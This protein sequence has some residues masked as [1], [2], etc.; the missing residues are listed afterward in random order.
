M[1]TRSASPSSP[2]T[3]SAS[4]TLLA[5]RQRLLGAGYRLFYQQPL[6]V[7]RGDGVWLYD[8]DGNRYLDVYNNV[9]S[10]G[11]CHPAVVEAI[12]TQAAT[13]NTHTRYLT[14]AI[15]DFAED[16]LQEFP[17]PLQNI[18]LTCS[19]SE[20][21]DLAL[22][23][24]R[25]VT[26]G[27]GVMVTRWAYHGV[28]AQL[29][30]LSPS[31]GSGAPRGEQVWL[32]DPPDGYRRQ[33]GCLLASVKQALAQMEQAGVRPAAMLFDTLF[34]SDGVFS[35]PAQEVQEAVRLVRSAG[36]LFIADEV[37][38]GF[39]RTGNHRWGFGAYGVVPDLVTLGK[40][41]G[42]GHPVAAVVGN[43]A[44]FEAFGRNQRYFNTFGGNPVSCR[45]AH[46][47]LHTLRREQLQDNAQR[48]GHYLENGLRKLAE[49]HGCIGDIRVYG[50][51]IGVELVTDRVTLQPDTTGATY[52]VNDLRQHRILLSATGPDGNILKIRPPLIFQPEHA[53]MLLH[54]LD[55]ALSRRLSIGD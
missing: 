9:A 50:L 41:M 22:R 19:G 1:N 27:S 46:A 4:E 11:H 40:P 34:S 13:L 7:V 26:G 36:G 49:R 48:M 44:W 23:I 35:A 21:N 16:F 42:N 2:E 28:T 47:V 10:L 6:H 15:L 20:S 55:N 39:G 53:D 3:A 12:A 51:F 32:I 33:P 43:P 8:A 24:A 17:A 5:R 31:L 52:V 45:A 37:Q 29:A 25:Y 14:D 54:E 38:A 18:T 30:G